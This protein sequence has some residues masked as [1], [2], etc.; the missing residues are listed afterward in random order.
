[1]TPS[2]LVLTVIDGLAPAALERGVAD[3]RAPTLAALLDRGTQIDD[4]IAAF[5][6]VTPVCTASI[7]TGTGPDEHRVPAMCWY[8][9]SEE[10]YVDYGSSFQATRAFGIGR[11]LTDTIYNLNMA[12][13]SRRTPTLFELLD[14]N[15][16]RTAG[17][18]FLMYR[19]RHRH[20]ATGETALARLVTATLF[21]H[22]VWGPR[23]LFYADLFASRETGCKSQL[24]LPGAR[25]DHSG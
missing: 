17:T 13:L 1:M 19:G 4:C 21:R 24:G 10:R 18:T 3:G 20:E 14:D 6:S 7:V 5:P 12:H 25:D 16:V 2:K 22:A 23:E 11:C 15:D 8:L 9:R